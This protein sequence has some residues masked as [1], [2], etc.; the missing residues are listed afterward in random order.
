METQPKKYKNMTGGLFDGEPLQYVERTTS[1]AERVTACVEG[2][3]H[4]IG[5]NAETG[6]RLHCQEAFKHLGGHGAATERFVSRCRTA[7]E[8]AVSRLPDNAKLR[9]EDAKAEVELCTKSILAAGREACKKQ[10]KA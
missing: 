6:F 5:Y 2:M 10:G 9:K 4:A 7:C 1:A 3:I 8:F